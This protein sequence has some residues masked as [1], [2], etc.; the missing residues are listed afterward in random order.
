MDVSKSMNEDLGF[1]GR[2]IEVAKRLLLRISSFLLDAA[3]CYRLHLYLF[4][5]SVPD[6]MPHEKIHQG[7]VVDRYSIDKLERL[8]SQVTETRPTTPLIEALERIAQEV[9]SRCAIVAITDGEISHPIFS[10]KRVPD[11]ERVLEGKNMSAL[12]VALSMNPH[13]LG[14]LM[15]ATR[16]V[17]LEVLRPSL[18][19][20]GVIDDTAKLVS[21][22]VISLVSLGP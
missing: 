12:I 15:S 13:F 17:H 19:H 2:K 11:L 18:L 3:G 4:P 5:S 8:L 21:A 1:L 6:L 10:S 14:A 22:K 16:R 9:E 7:L 20:S